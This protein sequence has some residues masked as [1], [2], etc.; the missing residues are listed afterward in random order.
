MG[1]TSFQLTDMATSPLTAMNPP[2]TTEHIPSNQFMN[3]A[4]PRE[5]LRGDA[6]FDPAEPSSS[7]CSLSLV[8]LTNVSQWKQFSKRSLAFQARRRRSP[9]MRWTK[10]GIYDNK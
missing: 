10:P 1:M 6:A 5:P 4:N 9:S 3:S 2:H 7:W 8:K